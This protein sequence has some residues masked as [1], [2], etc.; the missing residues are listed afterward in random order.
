MTGLSPRRLAAAFRA[1]VGLAPKSYQRVRRLQAALQ[2]A[3][4]R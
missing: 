1:E 3:G 4:R 2:T